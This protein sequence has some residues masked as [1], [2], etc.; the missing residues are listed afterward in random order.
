MAATKFGAQKPSISAH[1]GGYSIPV[2]IT[3]ALEEGDILV[4]EGYLI[5]VP[6]LTEI[7]IDRAI[8]TLPDGDYSADK[9]EALREAVRLKRKEEYPP[10]EEYL[11]GI[12]KGDEDQVEAYKDKCRAVKDKYPLP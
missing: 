6:N 1:M 7:E 9:L 3:T 2:G 4:Y 10:M 12:A 11:D 5:D 8:A